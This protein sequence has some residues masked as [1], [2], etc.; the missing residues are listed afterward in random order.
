MCTKSQQYAHESPAAAKTEPPYIKETTHRSMCLKSNASGIKKNNKK[1][2][3][4][5][6]ATNN[7]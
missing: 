4:G 7:H 2:K 1:K 6:G 3:K 5:E